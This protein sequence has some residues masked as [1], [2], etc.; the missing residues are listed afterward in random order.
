MASY[1]RPSA[2]GIL[3][4]WL[5]KLDAEKASLSPAGGKEGKDGSMDPGELK[6]IRNSIHAHRIL[7]LGP[8]EEV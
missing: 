5:A 2:L 6:R 4:G 1:E 8:L 7:I 3:N